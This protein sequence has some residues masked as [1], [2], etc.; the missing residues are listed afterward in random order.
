MWGGVCSSVALRKRLLI[1]CLNGP[2]S[3]IWG[4]Y[5][6]CF[7]PL[8]M[9]KTLNL[10]LCLFLAVL[11]CCLH[12]SQRA[13][14]STWFLAVIDPSW[15]SVGFYMFQFWKTSPSGLHLVHISLRILGQEVSH[16]DA[17]HSTFKSCSSAMFHW[18]W[19]QENPRLLPDMTVSC[20]LY[21]SPL[22]FS[23]LRERKISAL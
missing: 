8:P 6:R 4:Q 2:A 16:G 5:V 7:F 12:L 13:C 18:Y 10:K 20:H 15:V 1:C 19:V 9:G 23:M 11:C 17:C 22:S 3:E 14:S 21:I